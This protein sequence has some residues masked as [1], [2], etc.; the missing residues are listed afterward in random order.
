MILKFK[1]PTFK[2]GQN[3]TV[4]LGSW[5]KDKLE[6]DQRVT[7]GKRYRYGIITHL[8]TC[9]YKDIPKVVVKNEHDRKCRSY[10]GLGKELKRIYSRYIKTDNDLKNTIFTCIGFYC[11]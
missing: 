11:R 6:I 5:A 3:F 4:R 1:N 8:I 9:R 10:V 7:L 2:K